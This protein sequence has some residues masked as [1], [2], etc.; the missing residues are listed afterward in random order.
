MS[1]YRIRGWQFPTRR[2]SSMSSDRLAAL[3]AQFSK[4]NIGIYLV[5]TQDEH[6]S[7]YTSPADNRRAYISGFTGSAG[8]AVISQ[9]EAALA[10]DGRY[11]LQAGKQLSPQWTLLK[12][13]VKGVPTWQEWAASQAASLKVNIGVDPKLIS[14][15]QVEELQKILESKGVGDALIP[16]KENL[17]DTVWGEERPSRSKDSIF[18]LS[19]EYTGRDFEDKIA[20][21]Q[22]EVSKQGG[23]AIVLSALDDI[24]WLFNL[25]GSDIP[26]NPVFFAYAIITQSEAYLYMDEEKIP[27]EVRKGLGSVKIKPYNDVFR[28]ATVFG[29]QLVSANSEKAP[30]SNASKL[31][32]TKSGSWA[33]V[34]AL[35]GIDNVKIIE[36][37]VESA[38]SVKNDTELEGARIAHEKD[39]VALCRY[40]AWLEKSLNEGLVISDYN[41]ALKCLE[42]REQMENFKGLSFDTIS[43]SG[44]NAAVIHY[45]PAEDS[46]YMVDLNQVYLLDSGG[47]YLEGTT[48]TTRTVHYGTPCA[49]EIKAYTLVLK[50]HIA[51]ARAVFPEG[52]NGYMLDTL[53]RQ[54][55]WRY[56]LDYR[57]GTGHGLGAFLNVHEGPMGIGFRPG[58]RDHPLRIGN[59]ISNEPGYYEDG[60][61]GIRI[62][63]VVAVKEIKTENNFGGTR[64]FGFETITQ[65]PFCQKLIDTKL[66]G[67]DEI[68]WINEYHQQVFDVATKYLSEDKDQL[69]IDWLKRE[70]KAL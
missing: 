61:F 14:Y 65:V 63:S 32:V 46:K 50:G 34:D 47:Q 36:S 68:D 59:V 45:S 4:H 20:E 30:K 6:Q 41:A 58:Y 33:L 11:F 37:P 64:F 25:R 12:Q 67:N 49:D 51:L 26:Y 2:L 17:I 43:S 24:A 60:K 3:R 57:H 16:I 1:I 52:S 69:T 62:E 19:R 38:K 10:T 21:L 53:A 8:T 7:E 55:L 66:L 54:H 27:A 29:E 9:R 44:P 22:K 31:L 70:T 5:L 42:F 35:G 15:G 13:G 48:D 56:G 39:G 18:A 28:D 40:L 23:T